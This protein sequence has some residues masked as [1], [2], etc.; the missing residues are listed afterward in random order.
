MPCGMKKLLPVI[1]LMAGITSPIATAIANAN[2]LF[3]G[4]AH[5]VPYF[6]GLS[7]VLIVA[8]AIGA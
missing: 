3:T 8:A 7:V 2:G 5:L 4:H 6:Y 1:L